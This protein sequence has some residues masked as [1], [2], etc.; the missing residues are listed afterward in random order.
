MN[1]SPN[2]IFRKFRLMLA[3]RFGY[4]AIIL[5]TAFNKCLV[6]L[7]V[8]CIAVYTVDPTIYS[9]LWQQLE[10]ACKLKSDLWDTV[11]WGR[12]WHVDFNAAKTQLVLFDQSSNLGYRCENEWMGL[13]LRKHHLLRCWDCLFVL[14]WI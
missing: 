4:W 3:S 8:S 13:F 11:D 2:L 9:D 7:I 5:I 12:K 1:L 6:Y 14:N 10:L